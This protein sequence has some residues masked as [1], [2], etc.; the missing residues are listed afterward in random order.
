VPL[1][2]FASPN[3]LKICRDSRISWSARKLRREK[4]KLRAC[5]VARSSAGRYDLLVVPAA[6][7][8]APRATFQFSGGFGGSWQSFDCARSAG[9]AL[10]YLVTCTFFCMCCFSQA[11]E[12]VLTQIKLYFATLVWWVTFFICFD[13]FDLILLIETC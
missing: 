10:N 11:G 1:D 4:I 6:L 3:P 2:L 9:I 13:L 7:I 5:F 8:C 12:L